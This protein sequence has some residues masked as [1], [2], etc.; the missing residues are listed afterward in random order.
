MTSITYESIQV[1]D[2]LPEL[3]FGPISR[4]TLAL[5][6]GG[7]GDR[8]PIHVDIDFAKQ[9]GFDDVFAHGL[10]SMAVLGRLIT[11]WV[12]QNQV[13]SFGVRFSAITQVHDVVTCSGK[14]K[15]KFVEGGEQFLSLAVSTQTQNG[16]Q[17]L[18][19]TAVVAF[20]E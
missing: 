4:H 1:G 15:D 16:R 12:P 13:R 8:N 11:G 7:S 18:Y 6:C 5:Y 10:L 14:V 19:G 20:P 9:A 2:T 17:T 3:I